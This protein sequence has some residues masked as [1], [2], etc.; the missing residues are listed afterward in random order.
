[1]LFIVYLYLKIEHNDIRVILLLEMRVCK[2][3]KQFR[4]SIFPKIDK[5]Y[6]AIPFMCLC[7]ENGC[8]IV[9]NRL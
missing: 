1:M 5:F 3:K 8:N 7:L 4:H 6:I 9:K 2:D